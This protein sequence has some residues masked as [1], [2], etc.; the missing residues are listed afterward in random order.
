MDS[1]WLQELQTS[2]QVCK[3]KALDVN[4]LNLISITQLLSYCIRNTRKKVCAA[5]RPHL[6]LKNRKH[7]DK[8]HSKKNLSVS[9]TARKQLILNYETL[10][11]TAACRDTEEQ[12]S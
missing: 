8:A 1:S 12:P 11:A 5:L 2:G 10:A 7:C 6:K 3:T 9:Y 4:H